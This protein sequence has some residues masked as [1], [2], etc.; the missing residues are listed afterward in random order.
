MSKELLAVL[1]MTDIEQWDWVCRRNLVP[2][3]DWSGGRYHKNVR[4]CILADLA[5]RLRDEV[6]GPRS[7]F[8]CTNL[9]LAFQGAWE[10]I[11]E[12]YQ[13]EWREEKDHLDCWIIYQAQ[14][15]HWIIAALIAKG[16]ADGN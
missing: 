16:M 9:S 6:S 14:P 7:I 8:D 11:A 13:F 4:D 3:C 1:D 12:H 15:I 2:A 5:F 10:Q